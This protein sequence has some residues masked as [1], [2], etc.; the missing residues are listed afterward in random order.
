MN[1]SSELLPHL[2]VAPYAGGALAALAV[3]LT[4]E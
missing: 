4:T 3:F 1:C 2:G